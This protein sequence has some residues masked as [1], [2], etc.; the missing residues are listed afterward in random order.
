MLC[1]HENSKQLLKRL[2]VAEF[3]MLQQPFKYE[4]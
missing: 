3:M 4:Y 2:Q 1:E